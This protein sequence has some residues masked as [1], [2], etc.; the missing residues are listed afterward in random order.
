MVSVFLESCWFRRRYV[1]T[2]FVCHSHT[3]RCSDTSD[4]AGVHCDTHFKLCPDGIVSRRNFAQHDLSAGDEF[5][6]SGA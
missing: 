3:E 5:M 1:L 6:W 4:E 2:A